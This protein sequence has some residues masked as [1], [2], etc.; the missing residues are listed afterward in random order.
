MYPASLRAHQVSDLKDRVKI[1]RDLV[2]GNPPHKVRGSLRDPMMRQIGLL[3]T[4]GCAARD[5]MCELRAIFDTVFKNVRYTGDITFKDTF[6]S[7]LKTLQFGGGDCFPEGTLFVTRD[8]FVPIEH[9]EVGDEIHDGSTWVPV[10]KTW[11]R[12]VKAVL[13]VSL[14]NGN[15]LRLTQNHK[16]LRVPLGGGYNDAEEVC[17]S[18]VRVGDDLLQ[19]RQFDGASVAETDPDTAFLIGA[20]LAEGCRIYKKKVTPE[21]VDAAAK[22][23]SLAGVAGGK[24]I[25]ERA[26]EILRARNIPFNEYTRELRFRAE[27]FA[28]SFE[29]GRTAID[30]GLPT[31][32]YGPQTVRA[33]VSALT[34]GDG[35]ESTTGYNI[36]YSTISPT[37]AL[38][39][40]VLQRMLGRSVAWNRLVEH[41][42]AGKNPIYRLTVRAE[43]TR[44]PWAKV[45]GIAIEDVESLSYDVMTSS[46]R[47]YLPECDVIT[48]QC[49]DHSVLNAVLAMEN[50][51]QAK[52]RI[53]SN[54]GTTWDHIYCMVGVPKH[55]PRSWVALDTTLGPGA[56]GREP[57][58]AKYE[59]FLVGDGGT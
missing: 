37:L 6:Q 44:R 14:D 11:E 34:Q 13:R 7:A 42:G 12:G 25:R 54:K 24:G 21:T 35:G 15:D 4:Q 48:R 50:G 33:I 3:V 8:G 32:Q 40:R 22:W 17:L 58:S 10:L 18:D 47:V 29:L 9:V 43:N 51:F 56:F 20:Y 27:H 41:G 19:P 30:K 55:A 28:E 5:D 31:L 45:R 52:W 46:G 59:D 39:Y 1:L 57:P 26:M 38:Q 49:D 53:T 16:V 23:V 2:W 36:V